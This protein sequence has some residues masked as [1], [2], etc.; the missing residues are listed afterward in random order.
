L[1]DQQF[2]ADYLE[3]ATLN[4]LKKD[5]RRYINIHAKFYKLKMNHQRTEN[6]INSLMSKFRVTSKS[7]RNIT[8][9]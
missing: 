5:Q 7:R 1:R 8:G 2:D 9:C 6:N 4:K 3:K